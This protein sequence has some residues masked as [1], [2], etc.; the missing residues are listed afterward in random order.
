MIR[1]T[2]G[3]QSQRWLAD[4]AARKR[5][6]A[7]P[8]T[9]H[10]FGSYVRRLNT[11]IGDMKLAEINNGTL[12]QLVQQLDKEKL[13]AKTINELVFVVK[14]V[15]G[16]LLDENT[17]EPLIKREW[18]AR[19]I[20]C[21]T[22][23]KQKQP[24]VTAKDVDRC[25]KEAASDQEAVLYAILAGTGLRIA[26][27]L[28]VRVSGKEDQTSWYPERQAIDVR[29]SLFNGKEIS[30][31]KTAAAKR[32]IDLD[33]RLN[34]LISR[35]VEAGKINLGHYLFQSRA[36]QA[37][38]VNTTRHWLADRG[39][40]GFHSF[41]RFFISRRR[42]LGFPEN[43]LRFTVGHSGISITDLYDQSAEDEAYRKEWCAKMGLGFELPVIVDAGHPAPKSSRPSKVFTASEAS[44][45]A[46]PTASLEPITD[47]LS[48]QATD[49]DLPL[50]LFQSPT[51]TL[52]E[53][54]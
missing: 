36:G 7:S 29:S 49:D 5:K 15:V 19:F 18:S 52:A 6:P 20:D 48:Y 31:L 23:T 24:C 17:G 35:Y 46:E 28:A 2:F 45:R 44:S 32:T 47:V 11:M 43:L 9:L 27:A 22:V 37:L 50:D 14:Q 42:S 21:P 51:E 1:I 8:A 25:I 26:E 38:H 12:K 3:E 4:L 13:S 41:R 30:R 16:S 34:D 33:P 54:K 40:P 53:F 39:I 10:A